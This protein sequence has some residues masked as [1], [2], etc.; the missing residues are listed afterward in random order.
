[1]KHLRHSSIL[2][3]SSASESRLLYRRRNI[4]KARSAGDD[5]EK[6]KSNEQSPDKRNAVAAQKKLSALYKRYRELSRS[7]RGDRKEGQATQNSVLW[8]VEATKHKQG[9]PKRRAALGY[10]QR[11]KEIADFFKSYPS[12]SATLKKQIEEASKPRQQ[13]GTPEKREQ[14]SRE[15]FAEFREEAIGKQPRDRMHAKRQQNVYRNA[16]NAIQRKLKNPLAVRQNIQRQIQEFPDGFHGNQER[17]ANSVLSLLDQQMQQVLDAQCKLDWGQYYYGRIDR[18]YKLSPRY[19][20]EQ[21]AYIERGID[22]LAAVTRDA[23][24]DLQKIIDKENAW[25]EQ[26]VEQTKE[27]VRR[28]ALDRARSGMTAK[29]SLE[30]DLGI[31]TVQLPSIDAIQ[32]SDIAQAYSQNRRDVEVFPSRAEM[33]GIEGDLL[34]KTNPKIVYD[35]SKEALSDQ[36]DTLLDLK[37]ANQNEF[38][39]LLQQFQK[40][41]AEEGRGSTYLRLLNTI[42]V[43]NAVGQRKL[44]IPYLPFDG[45]RIA[46]DVNDPTKGTLVLGDQWEGTETR[47]LSRDPARLANGREVAGKALPRTFGF[48]LQEAKFDNAYGTKNFESTSISVSMSSP[49]S[50]EI[51]DRSTSQSYLYKRKETTE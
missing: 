39:G 2:R 1:M 47:T 43:E 32:F 44:E 7:V 8:Q 3:K 31:L 5:A 17:G 24:T 50:I 42:G 12:Q 35:S 37:V 27:T 22:G 33:A 29:Q 16:L 41:S 14:S 19:V 30:Q 51:F 26:Q 46:P 13:T 18:S 49:N 4:N 10:A 38:S 34:E 40:I 6:A 23:P 45:V 36:L 9:S 20:Q 15:Q 25:R 21:T 11:W 48:G 28:V